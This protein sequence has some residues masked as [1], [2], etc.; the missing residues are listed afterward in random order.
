M[1]VQLR[2]PH[3][4]VTLAVNQRYTPEQIIHLSD[5][6]AAQFMSVFQLQDPRCPRFQILAVLHAAGLVDNMRSELL[7]LPYAY[8]LDNEVAGF[9]AVL[10]DF[11]ALPRWTL[12][13]C[14]L[15]LRAQPEVTV[16]DQTRRWIAGYLPSCR[17]SSVLSAQ[18]SSYEECFQHKS[19]SGLRHSTPL[20]PVQ[21]TYPVPAQFSEEEIKHKRWQVYTALQARYGHQLPVLSVDLVRDTFTHIDHY[22]FGGVLKEKIAQQNWIMNYTLSKGT[23]TAGCIKRKGGTCTLAMSRPIFT[24]LRIDAQVKVVQPDPNVHTSTKLGAWITVVEHETIHLLMA[25]IPN[26]SSREG[27]Y[28]PHGK[29]FRH[30]SAAI[31]N[32]SG[33]YH[34]LGLGDVE[35][36][37]RKKEEKSNLLTDKKAQLRVG[38]RV[39]V[40]FKEG[41][42]ERIVVKLNPKTVGVSRTGNPLNPKTGNLQHMNVPYVHVTKI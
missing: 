41:V 14:L 6:L 18:P 20:G 4:T 36:I 40:R 3:G 13:Q 22:F 7:A 27:D 2:T 24:N 9:F 42:R 33:I 10:G 31:F 1:A 29:C 12:L 28:T 32:Q 23:K 5:E 34:S 11:S 17:E 16:N 30:L 38:D 26:L 21:F 39:Q 15:V 8:L 19:P 35:T 25:L 37:T